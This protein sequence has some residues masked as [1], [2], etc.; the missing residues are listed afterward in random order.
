MKPIFKIRCSQLY[1]IMANPKEKSPK[2]K[3]CD[4][5]LEVSDLNTKYEL[6]ANK[7][8]KTAQAILD[9]IVIKSNQLKELEPIKD[10]TFLSKTC[11]SYLSEWV[12]DK[13][14]GR[15]KELS[16][17]ATIKGIESEMEAIFIL[18]KCYGKNYKK[19][20]E[21]LEND[22]MTG[23]RDI[24]CKEDMIIRDTKVAETIESFP[25]LGKDEADL[26]YWWQQ[27][28]YMILSGQ[29]YKKAY[30]DKVL[31]NSP[32]WMVQ[33]E[34]FYLFNSLEKRYD[35]NMELVE[36][37]FADRAKYIFKRHVFDTNLSVLCGGTEFKLEQSDIIPVQKRVHTIEVLRED[38]ENEIRE[39]VEQCRFYLKENGY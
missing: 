30:I 13:H 33:Q 7:E 14:Y 39:R 24:L 12:A 27:Q 21:H 29:E 38:V 34:L 15:P 1:K 20:T 17:R 37:E 28:G 19:D 23:H 6:T 3:Y 9:K 35:G 2:D 5:V 18:N 36:E 32:A 10:K 4:L 16:T 8:T 11:V 25:F 26:I 31:V 22:F